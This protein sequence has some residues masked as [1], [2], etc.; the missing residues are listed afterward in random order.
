[1]SDVVQNVIV[2]LLVAAAALYVGWTIVRWWTR[3][4]GGSCGACHGC[5][6]AKPGATLVSLDPLPNDRH[7]P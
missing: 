4:P 3:K 1:M 2:F 6:Q 7:A 5:A